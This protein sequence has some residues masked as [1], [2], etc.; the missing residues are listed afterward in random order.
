MRIIVEAG[1]TKCKW[2]LTGSRTR[3]IETIGFNPN[4][5]H[6]DGL[7]GIAQAV[8]EVAE[9]EVESVLYFGAGCGNRQNQEL[10][11]DTLSKVFA[12]ATIKV[13]SDLE[14][15]AIALFGREHGIAAILGTGASA[16][17]YNGCNIIQQAPSLGYLLGD[18]G[19]GAYLG[20]TLIQKVLRSEL[21]DEIC[22]KFWDF[23]KST[24]SELIH[25]IYM[26]ASANSLLASFA[27]F[28]SE[29]IGN[30]QIK[31][32]VTNGIAE[33]DKK[34]IKV[35][36]HTDLPLGFVGGIAHQFSDMLKHHFSNQGFEIKILKDAYSELMKNSI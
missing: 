14:G 15:A 26:S 1:G 34:H 20:K 31:A 4:C 30:E 23:A 12:N 35:L 24:P 36:N 8:A 27:P 25:N 19:S 11:C 13:C 32:I 29:N 9:N 22:R 3:T 7:L 17:V 2:G 21:S 18:E 16:G 28:L 5:G 33:F 6:T 10:V